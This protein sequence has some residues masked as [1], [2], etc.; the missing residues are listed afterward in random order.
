MSDILYTINCTEIPE[1][2]LTFHGADGCFEF[3]FVE[4]EDYTRPVGSVFLKTQDARE[5]ADALTAWAD[6]QEGAYVVVVYYDDGST[7]RY[8]VT[9]GSYIEA[10]GE[11]VAEGSILNIKPCAAVVTGD[12]DVR[13]YNV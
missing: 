10:L 2:V 1:D 12:D 7:N 13:A 3:G 5:L 8:T 4:S 9:A 6:A 11:G